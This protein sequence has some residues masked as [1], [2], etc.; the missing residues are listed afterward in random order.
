M[1]SKPSAYLVA[2]PKKAETHIQNIAPGPP[3]AIAVATP[4]ILPVPIVADMARHN[5]LKLL[6]SPEPLFLAVNINFIASGNLN[7]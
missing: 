7:T 2:I 5:A 3:T 1:A 4:T 6:I